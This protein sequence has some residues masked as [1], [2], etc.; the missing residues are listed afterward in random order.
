LKR[1]EKGF[2]LQELLICVAIMVSLA[3]LFF[4]GYLSQLQK[5][6]DGKRLA[7]LDEIENSLEDYFNDNGCYPSNVS[8]FSDTEKCGNKESYPAGFSPWL[9]S[10]PCDTLGNPYRVIVESSPCPSWYMV[11]TN[12][13]HRASPN[14]KSNPCFSGCR[15]SNVAY[16]Y[17]ISSSNI[18]PLTDYSSLAEYCQ[19]N[20]FIRSAEAGGEFGPCNGPILGEN[21]CPIESGDMCFTTAVTVGDRCTPECQVPSCP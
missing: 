1:K 11:Y 16:N 17:A 4:I 19:G 8:M 21:H 15:I 10:I 2:T 9:K 13:E 20:C 18:M 6:R 7:D 5:G 12:M 3:A 14:I